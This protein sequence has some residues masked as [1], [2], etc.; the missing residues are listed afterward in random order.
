MTD[1]IVLDVLLIVLLI[2]YVVY[3]F[4]NGL[5]RSIFVIAGVVAGAIAAFFVLSGE[6]E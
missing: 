1:A 4:R 3:G 2:A 5:S 6:F